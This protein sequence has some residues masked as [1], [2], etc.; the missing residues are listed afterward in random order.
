MPFNDTP[1]G[2]ESIPGR[3]FPETGCTVRGIFLEFFQRFGPELC[4][5]PITDAI[6]ENGLVTQ[7]FQRLAL[8]ESPQGVRLK[9]LGSELLALRAELRRLRA[10][11]ATV[12]LQNDILLNPPPF[13]LTSLVGQL[14]VHPEEKYPLRPLSQVRTLVIHH[15][16]AAPETPPSAIADHHVFRLGWPGIGYHFLVSTDGQIIQTN[17]LAVESFHARQFNATSIGIA[18]SG[19]LNHATP[20]PPQIDALAHLCAWL[21]DGL[22]LPPDAILGHCELV[23]ATPCPGE[24]WLGGIA[25]KNS[26]LNRLD[27]LLHPLTTSH[28]LP[29]SPPSPSK[30][31]GIEGGRRGAGGEGS[32]S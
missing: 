21:L 14:A 19:N 17:G 22:H 10:Q 1:P 6:T 31:G 9:P 4:G 20:P 18:L 27:T 15:T 30:L 23:T 11:H 7:Y 32:P 28:S 12:S 25:W 16:G 5:L 2:P 13:P 29:P 24:D 8:E 3:F 26:L